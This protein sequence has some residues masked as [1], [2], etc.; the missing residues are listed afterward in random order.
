MQSDGNAEKWSM[1]RAL[2]LELAPLW[3]QCMEEGSGG[4]GCERITMLSP[5]ELPLLILRRRPTAG[6]RCQRSELFKDMQHTL[7]RM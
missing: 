7:L 5:R 6:T 4:I 3:E 2:R 1:C